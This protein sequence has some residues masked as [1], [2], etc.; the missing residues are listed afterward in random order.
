MIEHL[1]PDL[2][3]SQEDKEESERRMQRETARPGRVQVTLVDG[4]THLQEAENT[5]NNKVR[6][7]DTVRLYITPSQT[8]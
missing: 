2:S 1:S 5:I 8:D 4:S 6:D 7:R 3:R